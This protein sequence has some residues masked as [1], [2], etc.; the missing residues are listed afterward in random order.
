MRKIL[1]LL[2]FS[3]FNSLYAQNTQR[4][5]LTIMPDEFWWSGISSLG[6]QTPYD[7]KT[8]SSFDMWGDN[9]GNQA[10]PLLLSSKGR[11]IWSEEPIKYDFNNGKL[12]V[13]TRNGNIITGTAGNNLQDAYNYAVKNYFPSSGK[14][15]DALMFTK[16]QYNTWI[17]LMYDQM[18]RRF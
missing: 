15:P 10:Q 1:F 7:N 4:I 5:D 14:I 3:S 13:T 2:L 18:R 17:E 6:H 11:Y 16:P 8:V 12:T 9:K